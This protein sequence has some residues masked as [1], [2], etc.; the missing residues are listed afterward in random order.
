MFYF[1]QCHQNNIIKCM[2]PVTYIHKV[3]SIKTLT[4]FCRKNHQNFWAKLLLIK[5]PLI[6][7]IFYLLIFFGTNPQQTLLLDHTD[8]TI[9]IKCRVLVNSFMSK[10]YGTKLLFESYYCPVTFS[11]NMFLFSILNWELSLCDVLNLVFV[12]YFEAG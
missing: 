12:S 7:T 1:T 6:C 11:W 9:R 3:W 4:S 8:H 10:I 2:S 5:G